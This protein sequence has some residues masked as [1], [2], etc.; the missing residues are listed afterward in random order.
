MR[1][2]IYSFTLICTLSAFANFAYA[3]NPKTNAGKLNNKA[4]QGYQA[5]T[6]PTPPTQSPVQNDSLKITNNAPLNQ[7]KDTSHPSSTP[8]KNNTDGNH[9]LFNLGLIMGI[10]QNQFREVSNNDLSIGVGLSVMYNFM[11]TDQ[12]EKSPVNIY[13]GGTFEYLYFGGESNTGSYD[14]TDY[15]YPAYNF[16]NSVTT[17]VNVNVYSLFLVSR[18]A[19]LNGPV[20]PFIEAAIGGRSF[21]GN[22]KI[23][24]IQTQTLKPGWSGQTYAPK[25]QDFNKNL[26]SDITGSY[27]YGG[28]FLFGNST[29]HLEIKV[30]YYKGTTAT[31]IDNESIKIDPITSKVTYSTK[32]ST[33]DMLIPQ[34]GI[35]ATF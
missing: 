10:P 24:A 7:E 18:I 22:E 20:I 28:G 21:D 29:I 25:Q 27:G 33:T 15:Y 30:M 26:E 23:T 31:Y 1:K 6:I 13:L 4:P 11:G 8:I 9:I 19:F 5:P 2:Q 3:Q 34:I 14:Y 32:T 35:S 17:N 16:N 12:K